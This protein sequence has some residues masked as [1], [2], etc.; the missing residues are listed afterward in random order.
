MIERKLK[1]CENKNRQW[2]RF[3]RGALELSHGGFYVTRGDHD[4]AFQTG[5]KHRAVIRHPTM[6]GFIHRGFER[7]VRDRRPAAEPAGG[8]HEIHIDAF[9]IHILNTYA[10]IALAERIGLAML[11]A[12][13]A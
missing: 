7:D 1:R 3:L 9:Q 4:N 11:V 5:G 12:L 2:P 8:Q 6:V 13:I 10:W